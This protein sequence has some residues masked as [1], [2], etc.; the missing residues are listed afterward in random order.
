MEKERR[1]TELLVVYLSLRCVWAE[2][3]MEGA[4]RHLSAPLLPEGK[5]KEL[6]QEGRGSGRPN[7]FLL[8][9]PS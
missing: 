9:Q 2:P 3:M 4:Q 7:L 1:N 6:S 8:P 5:R